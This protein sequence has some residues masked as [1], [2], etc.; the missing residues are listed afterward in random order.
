ME[1]DTEKLCRSL[2]TEAGA[3]WTVLES[4]MWRANVFVNSFKA[5]V[6][7]ETTQNKSQKLF[8]AKICENSLGHSLK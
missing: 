4:S 8:L 7:N 3:L 6:M 5:N 1:I 2:Y